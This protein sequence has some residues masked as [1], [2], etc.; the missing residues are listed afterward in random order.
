MAILRW[1]PFHEIETLRR[2]F[3]QLFSELAGSSR[4]E[5]AWMPAIELQDSEQNLIIR[6][7]IPGVSPNDIDIQATKEAVFISGEHRYENKAEE[8]GYVRSEFRYGKFQRVI[9]LPV[10]IQNDQVK[11]DFNHGVLTLTLP[12]AQAMQRQVVKI[13]LGDNQS[14]NGADNSKTIESAG[15]TNKYQAPD[16]SQLETA[17]NSESVTTSS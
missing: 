2:Q 16:Q 15:E 4:D 13:N 10:H 3:D 14:I 12:K 9:P 7:Q 8:E 1:Q 5:I 6:A 17:Q 11:A